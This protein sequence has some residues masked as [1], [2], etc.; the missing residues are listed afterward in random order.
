[1]TVLAQLSDLHLDGGGHRLERAR[2]V[3]EHLNAMPLDAVLVTGDIADHGD[4]AEYAQARKVL[5]SPHPVLMCPGNHDVRET[6]REALLGEEPA[7]GPINRVGRAG[8]V[9]VAMCDSTVPG[10]HHGRLDAATLAWLERV[11][12]GETGPAVV[13]MHH[14]PAPLGI[15]YVDEI[16][17]S[18]EDGLAELLARHP[19]VVAVLTGHAHTAAAT[20]FAG[21]PLAVAP[22]VAST[23]RLPAERAEVID[24]AAPPGAALHVLDGGRLTT[25]FRTF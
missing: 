16:R 18:G 1:M 4:P 6:Y 5:R 15:P 8:G 23:L 7:G 25:H 11:L 19:R 2:R 3:M 14:P 17:S 10:K 13:C 21:R 24:P 22:G 12:G 9:L 20:A